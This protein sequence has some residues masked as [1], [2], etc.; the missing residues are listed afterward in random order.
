MAPPATPDQKSELQIQEI[1]TQQKRTHSDLQSNKSI[2]DQKKKN[3]HPRKE[4]TPALTPEIEADVMA[5]E[6]EKYPLTFDQSTSL[7]E[8]TKGIKSPINTMEEFIDNPEEISKMFSNL[9]KHL[10]DRGTKRQF[11][12]LINKIKFLKHQS[13]I[14]MTETK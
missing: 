2:E 6:P 12:R 4:S 14:E 13:G 8:R 9:F 3:I 5:K 1:I 10:S 11:S 7:L